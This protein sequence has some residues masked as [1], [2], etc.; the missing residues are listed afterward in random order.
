MDVGTDPFS[1][2]QM[3]DQLDEIQQAN[4]NYEEKSLHALDHTPQHKVLKIKV[5]NLLIQSQN[6]NML[7]FRICERRILK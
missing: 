2:D 6:H 4:P 5:K 1:F 7:R 3:R